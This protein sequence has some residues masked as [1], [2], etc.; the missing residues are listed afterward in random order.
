MLPNKPMIP[1]AELRRGK[2]PYKGN[3]VP[4][5]VFAWEPDLPHARELVVVTRITGPHFPNPI[6]Q[7]FLI[8]FSEGNE[9]TVWTRPLNGW[10]EAGNEM[11]RFREAVV[12]TAFNRML[13]TPPTIE[14]IAK[15]GWPFGQSDTKSVQPGG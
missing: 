9:L 6:E 12:P 3:I 14:E 15:I 11:S 7:P 1:E 8:D 5:D 10:E 4:G 13:P 2:R